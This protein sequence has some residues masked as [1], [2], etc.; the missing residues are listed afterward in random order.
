MPRSR[1]GAHAGG[2]QATLRRPDAA[3]RP[4]VLLHGALPGPVRADAGRAVAYPDGV[5]RPAAGRHVLR[6][7]DRPV[8]ALRL[9]R[10]AGAVP[11]TIDGHGLL[12][13]EWIDRK[14]TRL[15]SSH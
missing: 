3:R 1:H 10:R 12:L 7:R 11:V 15:N 9:Y 14:S 8:T 2:P 13:K 5:P 4:V 6:R